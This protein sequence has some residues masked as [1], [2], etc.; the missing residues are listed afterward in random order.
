MRK[1]YYSILVIFGSLLYLPLF[2]NAT[3]ISHQKECHDEVEFDYKEGSEK[4]PSKWG[5][6]K[7]EWETCKCGKMQSPIDLSSCKVK[8]MRKMGHKKHY[9]PSNSTIKN[10]GHDIS[11]QW[12]GDAGSI[13]MNGTK[14]SLLQIHWHFPS[15]HTINGRRYALEL[16]M[17]HQSTEEKNKKVVKAVLYKLGRPDPFLFT[18]RRHVFSMID[19]EGAER[20]LGMINPNYI[21]NMHSKRYYKYKGSLTIPP[22]TEV[23]SVIDS[24]LSPHTQP[25]ESNRLDAANTRDKVKELKAKLDEFDIA[26]DDEKLVKNNLIWLESTISGLKNCL[27]LLKKG[28]GIS[29]NISKPS[30][31]K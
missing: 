10:R 1:S 2:L 12:H 26:K 15:E 25:S 14:Y 20:N 13:W 18:L 24:F 6:L 5:E 4:G 8:I 7:K 27:M 31:V 9:K 29:N 30:A 11:L 19:Q 22:C 16:H 21:A 17:V 3:S 28:A 23:N